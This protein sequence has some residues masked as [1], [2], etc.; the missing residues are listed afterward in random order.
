MAFHNAIAFGPCERRLHWRFVSL[1]AFAKADQFWDLRR[2]NLVEPDIELLLCSMMHHI[3]E[4]LHQI[5]CGFQRRM[6]AFEKGQLLFFC[7]DEFL[8]NAHVQPHRLFGLTFVEWPWRRSG[9]AWS[10]GSRVGVV[11]LGSRGTPAT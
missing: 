6:N 4:C 10:M 2:S 9:L 5:I 8:R 1:N 11:F 7:G 3:E